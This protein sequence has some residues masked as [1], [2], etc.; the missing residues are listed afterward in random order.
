MH[1]TKLI[2]LHSIE[3]ITGKENVPIEHI[4][5]YLTL[6]YTSSF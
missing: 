1:L 5:K 4:T 2:N 6:F 3:R